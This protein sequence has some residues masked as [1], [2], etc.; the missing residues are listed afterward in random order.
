M[1]AL[2]YES[3]SMTGLDGQTNGG[4]VAHSQPQSPRAPDDHSPSP[5]LPRIGGLAAAAVGI[6][7]VVLFGALFLLGWGPHQRREAELRT[8]A[9]EARD[10]KPIVGVARLKRSQAT[11]DL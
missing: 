10:A 3:K 4:D 9:T 11:S 1:E 5:D 6:T 7:V 2:N 8:D